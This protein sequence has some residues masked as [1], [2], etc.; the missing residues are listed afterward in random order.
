MLGTRSSSQNDAGEPFGRRPPTR[1]AWSRRPA[2]FALLFAVGFA[3]IAAAT[4]AVAAVRIGLG[5]DPPSASVIVGRSAAVGIARVQGVVYDASSEAMLSVSGEIDLGNGAYHLRNGTPEDFIEV[6]VVE[7]GKYFRGSGESA[8]A[9]MTSSQWCRDDRQED[10]D[11]T[12][13]LSPTDIIRTL[14]SRPGRLER[15]GRE[16]VR[17]VETTH[18]SWRSTAPEP[19]D[20]W[21]DENDV[22]RRVSGVSSD[23]QIDQFE[24]YDFGASLPPVTAPGDAER[25]PA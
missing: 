15:V 19:L 17:G 10:D 6:L 22:L 20:V 1:T 9:E 7:D 2:G 14:S 18:Y 23:N 4:V 13:G 12:F 25:C 16:L 21:V 24:F 11:V 5:D 8:I 3:V